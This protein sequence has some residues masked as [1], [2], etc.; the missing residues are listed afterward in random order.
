MRNLLFI[1]I[2]GV[3]SVLVAAS[4]AFAKGASQATINGPGLHKGGLV[5]KSGNG[6][7]PTAGSRL[8][9]LATSAGFFPAVFNQ[10]PDP[11][12]RDR[13]KGSLGPKYTVAYVM[14]GPNSTSSTIRQDLYPYAKPYALSYTKPGQRFW[15]RG[16]TTHGGWFLTTSAV[17]TTLGLPAQPPATGADDGSGWLRWVALAITIAAGLALIGVL[18]LVA[19][20]RRPRPAAA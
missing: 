13:P 18:S 2:A 14:P 15:D 19:L 12:L 17:R 11:M 20:R 7:D 3:F 10:A 16:Q 5:L 1:F 9:Q 4:A 6:G 8:E